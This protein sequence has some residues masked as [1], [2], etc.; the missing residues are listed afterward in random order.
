MRQTVDGNTV[1]F[2]PNDGGKIRHLEY[3]RFYHRPAVEQWG[4]DGDPMDWADGCYSVVDRTY[5]ISNLHE[6]A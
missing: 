6:I 1:V 5:D 3:H 4:V 2:V